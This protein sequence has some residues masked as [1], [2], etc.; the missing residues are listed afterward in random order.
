[1]SGIWWTL[2]RL[3]SA[4]KSSDSH[5][6]YLLQTS[7]H[8]SVIKNTLGAPVSGTTWIILG[9]SAALLIAGLLIVI[10]YRKRGQKIK[11][12]ITVSAVIYPFSY[13]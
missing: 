8:N 4:S 12:R 9:V 11:D 3:T 10:L 2:K 13:V 5:K 1:M 6:S 7:F